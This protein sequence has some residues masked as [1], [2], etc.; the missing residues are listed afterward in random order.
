MK[1]KIIQNIKSVI[2]TLVLVLGVSYVSASSTWVAPTASAPGNNTDVPLN[3]G[4]VGQIKIGGL[5]LNTG[6]AANGLIVDKGN[7]GIGVTTPTQKLDVSGQIHASGDICTDAG[8]GKCLSTVGGTTSGG[9]WIPSEIETTWREEASLQTAFTTC[10]NL[11]NGWHLPTTEELRYFYL[12]GTYIARSSLLTI[13]GSCSSSSSSICIEMF[14][15]TSGVSRIGS[16][17][18]LSSF[19]CVR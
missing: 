10:K 14:D 8:G 3:V 2:L 17:G 15:M 18:I 5:T 19:V 12:S 9:G 11:G 16:T 1:T 13:S 7:V 6:G 4:S